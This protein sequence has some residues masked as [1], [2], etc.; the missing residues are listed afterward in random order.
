MF[1]R[2]PAAVYVLPMQARNVRPERRRLSM[3][4]KKAMTK[5]K[6]ERDGGLH[7]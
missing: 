3:R 5:K 2:P 1:A 6:S 7:V 4:T